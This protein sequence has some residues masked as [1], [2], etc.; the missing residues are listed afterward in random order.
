M[1]ARPDAVIQDHYNSLTSHNHPVDNP[2][3]LQRTYE[4]NQSESLSASFKREPAARGTT[5]SASSTEHTP[6]Q[7]PPSAQPFRQASD[8]HLPH[9]HTQRVRAHLARSLPRGEPPIREGDGQTAECRE[10]EE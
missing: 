2:P 1:R 7:M 10:R 6:Q 5:T 9:P 3:T 8:V 4:P